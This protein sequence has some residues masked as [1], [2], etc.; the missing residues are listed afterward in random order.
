MILYRNA[1]ID[2]R[3]SGLDGYRE[4]FAV[5]FDLFY[6]CCSV[7]PEVYT[8]SQK[9]KKPGTTYQGGEGDPKAR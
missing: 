6:S 3:E 2:E 7:L 9:G 8:S 5:G 1:K 4:A